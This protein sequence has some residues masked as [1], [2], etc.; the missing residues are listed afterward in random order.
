M[1]LKLRYFRFIPSQ[2]ETVEL[3]ARQFTQSWPD[4]D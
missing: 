4:E 3:G 1:L 2:T